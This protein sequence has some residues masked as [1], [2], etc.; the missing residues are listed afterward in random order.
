MRQNEHTNF[1]YSRHIELNTLEEE[2]QQHD[3]RLEQFFFCSFLSIQVKRSTRRE[4]CCTCLD[5][6]SASDAI[7]KQK[8]FT[9]LRWCNQKMKNKKTFLKKRILFFLFAVSSRKR[10]S[11]FSRFSSNRKSI[12]LELSFSQHHHHLISIRSRSLNLHSI[13]IS[14]INKNVYLYSHCWIDW[15][16]NKC[17]FSSCTFD[18][19]LFFAHFIFSAWLMIAISGVISRKIVCNNISSYPRWCTRRTTEREIWQYTLMNWKWL[20][21][22]NVISFAKTFMEFIIKITTNRHKNMK[23]NCKKIDDEMLVLL[24]MD[25][26]FLARNRLIL[27]QKLK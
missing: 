14:W 6:F 17:V 10:K 9:S 2:K 11:F 4:K 25:I 27:I 3:D 8:H 13:G 18:V 23:K 12:I 5:N 21:E 15:F 24:L 16:H 19:L 1:N 26:F 20:F 22:Q 7:Q